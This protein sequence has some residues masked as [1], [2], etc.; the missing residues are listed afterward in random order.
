MKAAISDSDEQSSAY[1][2]KYSRAV[3]VANALAERVPVEHWNVVVRRMIEYA[4]GFGCMMVGRVIGFGCV[5]GYA[6]GH[7]KELISH[8]YVDSQ[9]GGV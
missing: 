6:I 8:Y 4:I 1:H 3:L 9:T 2:Q 7:E 5:I